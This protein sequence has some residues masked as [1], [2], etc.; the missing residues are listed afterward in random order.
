[1]EDTRSMTL[2]KRIL[3][4][5][6]RAGMTQDQL[7]ERMGI[8]PQA[9][10]KWEHDLSCPDVTALPRLAEIFGITTD[11]LLGLTPPQAEPA[12]EGIVEELG[13][14]IN[15]EKIKSRIWHINIDRLIW[16]LF[17]IAL[18]GT[19]LT[20]VLLELQID[21]WSI[22]W[23]L[24]IFFMG[25]SIG[26]YSAVSGGA[27]A[28]AGLYFLLDRFG[29]IPS[30]ITWPLVLGIAL[31][32]LGVI[33]ILRGLFH[34]KRATHM[35]GSTSVN[36]KAEQPTRRYEDRDGCI[37]ADYA[38]CSDRITVHEEEFLGG[39]VEVAFGSLVMDLQNCQRVGEQARLHLDVAFGSLLLIV[40]RCFRTEFSLDRAASSFDETGSC[41]PD[42]ATLLVT[43]DCAFSSVKVQYI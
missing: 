33:V 35:A 42:A 38:F 32:L 11:E 1:M 26:K 28:I 12:K 18:G 39:D 37:H 14:A 4:Y 29:V 22:L 36:A 24:A 5:R 8:S 31:V 16:A 7:A 25:L 13:S 17:L 20:S 43:G 27:C 34:K 10:S 6:K 40:P 21:F 3:Y 23:P 2:G 30:F 15:M 9:V 19:Y 41:D